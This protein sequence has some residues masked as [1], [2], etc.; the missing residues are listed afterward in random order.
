MGRMYITRL[1]V[2]TAKQL[3]P[4]WYHLV[5]LLSIRTHALVTQDPWEREVAIRDAELPASRM[6][7]T[8]R[9]FTFILPSSTDFAYNGT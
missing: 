2:H 6:T 7:T 3:V 1:H 4:S 9:L 8:G 5:F